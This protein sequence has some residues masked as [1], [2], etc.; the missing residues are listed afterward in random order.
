MDPRGFGGKMP[1]GIGHIAADGGDRG[2]REPDGGERGS[3]AV[4]PDVAAVSREEEIR[5]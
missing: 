4:D 2:T 1:E 3:R 5:P